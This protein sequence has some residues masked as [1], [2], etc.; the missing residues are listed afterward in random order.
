MKNEQSPKYRCMHHKIMKTYQIHPDSTQ[1]YTP[2]L[3]LSPL[4]IKHIAYIFSCLISLYRFSTE[5]SISRPILLFRCETTRYFNRFL[6][7]KHWQK[8]AHM[9]WRSLY[10]KGQ[11]S[12]VETNRHCWQLN[13]QKRTKDAPIRQ[14]YTGKKLVSDWMQITL[15]LSNLTHCR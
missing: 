6:N 12:H 11:T 8:S 10:I 13:N 14:K 15:D 9:G 4:Q 3:H 2:G 7:R 1:I 5:R